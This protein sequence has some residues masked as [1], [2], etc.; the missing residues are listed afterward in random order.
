MRKNRQSRFDWRKP[1]FHRSD[2]KIIKG[3]AAR[4]IKSNA[5]GR[6]APTDLHT[7]WKSPISRETFDELVEKG[8]LSEEQIANYLLM[9]KQ[10]SNSTTRTKIG[11]HK[12]Y[13]LI[14][15]I[16]KLDLKTAE[17]AKAFKK[18]VGKRPEALRLIIE[19]QELRA[20]K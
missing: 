1:R 12:D 14:V 19:A 2:P 13:N 5:A 6:L 10:K 9:E 18:L 4:N 20:A 16:S 17:G 11:K 7:K 3:K 15:E 8:V